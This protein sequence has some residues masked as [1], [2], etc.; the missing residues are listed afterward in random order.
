[1]RRVV[2][3]CLVPLTVFFVTYPCFVRAAQPVEL[4]WRLAPGRVFY[5]K[6]TIDNRQKLNVMGQDVEDAAT[7]EYAFRYQVQERDK[8]GNWVLRQWLEQVGLQRQGVQMPAGFLAAVNGAQFT[9]R[10]S[11]EMRVTRI[12]LRDG[13]LN[14]LRAANPAWP[15]MF[16]SILSETIHQQLVEDLFPAG[17]PR[18]IQQGDSWTSTGHISLGRIGR[19][20]TRSQNT[21]E[22]KQ[23]RG[24]QVRVDFSLEYV[25][26]TPEIAKQLLF[27]VKAANFQAGPESSAAVWFHPEK[28]RLDS[29]DKFLDLKL[30]LVVEIGDLQTPVEVLQQ[31]KVTAKV[32]DPK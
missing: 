7:Y 26:P 25:P 17:T 27:R 24:E 21:Y 20:R 31:Q 12:D 8:Q 4:G 9:V 30:I 3:L 22:G 5:Q 2:A 13:L 6:V 16:E 23:E 10:L 11:P 14:R 15:A 29:S 28:G 19:L 18:A 1:M 32:T